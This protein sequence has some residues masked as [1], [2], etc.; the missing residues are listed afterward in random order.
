MARVLERVGRVKKNGKNSHHGYDYVTEADLVDAVRGHLAQEGV[1]VFTT[2]AEHTVNGSTATVTLELEFVDGESG[3]AYKTQWV[4]QG[5]DKQD[6]AYYKAYT[7]AMK[8]ALMKT[9]LISTGDDPERDA[10]D[11]RGRLVD[12]IEEMLHADHND[13]GLT[14]RELELFWQWVGDSKGIKDGRRCTAQQLTDIGKGLKEKGS[15]RFAWA[16]QKAAEH[17]A[18][19]KGKN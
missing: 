4:G 16:A 15:D 5:Q 1:M 18:T 14:S 2:V 8:Y 10:D 13:D 3:D 12:R 6:K 7:G 17:K 9:F 19:L 11:Q